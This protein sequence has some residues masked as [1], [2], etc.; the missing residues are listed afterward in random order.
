[1]EKWQ[2]IN[3]IFPFGGAFSPLTG[4]WESNEM[5]TRYN[6]IGYCDDIRPRNIIVKS[7]FLEWWPN[8]DMRK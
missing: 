2:N 5:L 1:M 4:E 3:Q 7:A 6:K 8:G